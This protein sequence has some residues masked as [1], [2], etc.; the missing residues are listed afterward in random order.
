MANQFRNYCITYNNPKETD[1]EYFEYLKS[2]EHI[3]YFAFQREA[4]EK[5]KTPHFQLYIEFN[6]G[7]KFDVMKRHFPTAHIEQRL[8]TK[9]QARD[10]CLKEKKQ[11]KNDDGEFET[12]ISGPYEFGEFAEERERTDLNDIMEMVRNG[13]V[14]S[15]IEEAYPSQYFRY[16]KNIEYLRQS[17]LEEAN[18]KKFRTLTT[19][20]IFGKAGIG[21]TRY[22]MEKYGYE[23]V[24]RVTNYGHNCFD[25]YKGHTVIL[26]EE[27]R[28]SVKVEE[29]L[30]Y[31]DGYPLMLPSRYSDKAACYTTAYIVTN[32]PLYEQYPQIQQSQPETWKAFLR[33][34]HTVYDFNISKENPINKTLAVLRPLDKPEQEQFPF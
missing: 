25:G 18:R 9:A 8:G 12:R 15:E 20:Y 28:S 4:G 26:F 24:Y 22:V 13:A 3:K 30:N 31:L 27:F 7:K 2:L 33:R 1:E 14:N 29:M 16:Y 10:Y 11:S 34:I 19:S 32:I 17:Y 21:K 23:N 6:I 5:N